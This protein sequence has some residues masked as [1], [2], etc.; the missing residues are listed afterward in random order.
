MHEASKELDFAIATELGRTGWRDALR[1][2]E[3]LDRSK[4][5]EAA[6]VALIDAVDAKD[7]K[8]IENALFVGRGLTF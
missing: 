8:R 7:S 6:L 5:L 1:T 4:E 2:V 3:A